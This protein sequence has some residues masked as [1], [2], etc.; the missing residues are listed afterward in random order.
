[1][2]DGRRM[3]R[4]IHLR[5]SFQP[6]LGFPPEFRIYRY[7]YGEFGRSNRP[8]PLCI[9][10][11][12]TFLPTMLGRVEG[13]YVGRDEIRMEALSRLPKEVWP[14][15]EPEIDSLIDVLLDL[16]EF[17]APGRR[18][19]A[20]HQR[21]LRV[22][23]DGE[24]RNITQPRANALDTVLLASLDP[25]IARILGLYWVDTE[26]DDP[27]DN[28]RFS[29]LGFRDY[30]V[31]GRW[32]EEPWPRTELDFDNVWWR[33]LTT[34]RLM[35]DDVQVSSN[36][37]LRFKQAARWIQAGRTGRVVS[38]NWHEVRFPADLFDQKPIFLTAMQTAHG[39][40]PVGVRIRGLDAASA[41]LRVE[42]DRRGP[43]TDEEVGHLALVSG[44]IYDVE[45]RPVGE[46]RSVRAE[47]DAPSEW[48]TASF[49]RVLSD[50]VVLMQIVTHHGHE[51]A[52]VRLKGVHGSGFK[53]K[54]EEW[55][56]LD[57]RHVE[58]ELN[59][60]ALERGVHRLTDGK[61]LEVGHVSTDHH[62]AEVDV[63]SA[64][65][66]VQRIVLSQAQSSEGGD[67]IIT[68]QRWL[69]NR[70][71]VR[72]QEGSDGGSHTIETVGYVV[73]GALDAEGE[74]G[75]RKPSIGE[76][77]ASGSSALPIHFILPHPV[78][79][80]EVHLDANRDGWVAYA[81]DQSP[82]HLD[83]HNHINVHEI[84][85]TRIRIVHDGASEGR[86][87]NRVALYHGPERADFVS[88]L[89]IHSFS[90]RTRSG[91][92]GDLWAETRW[93]FR[94][95]VDGEWV[96]LDYLS[97]NKARI[98]YGL[99][100]EEKYER[101][102][103]ELSV[104]PPAIRSLKQHALSPILG[105]GGEV[106]PSS[107]AVTVESYL[108]TAAYEAVRMNVRRGQPGLRE[109]RPRSPPIPSE[110]G[111]RDLHVVQAPGMFVRVAPPVVVTPAP[112]LVGQRNVDSLWEDP[113]SGALE[114]LI[115][116]NSN[117][118]RAAPYDYMDRWLTDGAYS[119]A[120]QG[121]DI[122][123]RVSEWGEEATINVIDRTPPPSPGGA[124][125]AYQSRLEGIVRTETTVRAG[126]DGI[127][128][129]RF[130]VLLDGG[131]R[132]PTGDGRLPL[133]G[134]DVD[135]LREARDATVR[136]TFRITSAAWTDSGDIR[137]EVEP[138]S[139]LT[140]A[141]HPEPGD[142]LILGY[143]L[144]VSVTWSW[145]GRQQLFHPGTREF[146]I[147]T[148]PGP[149]NAIRTHVVRVETT[150]EG[151]YT[152]DT[153]VPV[154]AVLTGRTGREVTHEWH[155]LTFP[156]DRL[157]GRPIFLAAMQ[158]AHGSDPSSVRVGDLNRE[159]AQFRVEEDRRGEHPRDERIAYLALAPGIVRDVAGRP[160][161]EARSLKRDQ[162][163]A[164]DPPR[165]VWHSV[166]FDREYAHPVV[167]MQ[168]ASRHGPQPA[169][170]RI[171]DVD[172]EGFR[173]KIEEWPHLDQEHVE[174]ELHFLAIEEGL[175]RLADGMLLEVGRVER[176]HRWDS[177][178]PV[179]FGAG[180]QGDP[181]VVYSQS[182]TVEGG[183]A[184]VTRQK[185]VS[186]RGFNVRLQEGSGDDGEH[187]LETVGYI[188]VGVDDAVHPLQ[189]SS[190]Q[191]DGHTYHLE[192]AEARASGSGR[193]LLRFHV[194][195]HA[196]PVLPPEEDDEVRIALSTTTGLMKEYTDAAI[197]QE[198]VGIVPLDGPGRYAG[199]V[200]EA[201]K[202]VA[203]ERAEL[204][205]R[206]DGIGVKLVTAEGTEVYR[207][208]LI[209]D[210]ELPDVGPE[211]F[212]P[213]ALTVGFDR[214]L[215]EP[216]WE[217]FD[218]L[219]HEPVRDDRTAVFI[220]VAP[221]ADRDTVQ[222]SD[223]N[224]VTVAYYYPGLRYSASV[225]APVLIPDGQATVETA[226]GVTATDGQRQTHDPRGDPDRYGNESRVFVTQAVAVDRARPPRPES[227]NVEID[228]ADYYGTSEATVEWMLP[229]HEE[230]SK[231]TRFNVYRATDTAVFAR[232]LQQR[233]LGTGPYRRERVDGAEVRDLFTAGSGEGFRPDPYFAEWF[234]TRFG[235]DERFADLF[236]D[237]AWFW[238]DAW[239]RILFLD[240]P[241]DVSEGDGD[242]A[243]ATW[244]EAWDKWGA[245]TDVWEAWAERFYPALTDQ[246]RKDL[247]ELEGNESAFVLVNDSP[248]PGRSIGY[249]VTQRTLDRLRSEE[250]PG[251]DGAALLSSLRSR[252][253]GKHFRG[254]RPFLDAL[255]DGLSAGAFDEYA[256]LVLR[257]AER[258]HID[259]VDGRVRNRYL[260]RIQSVGE[261]VAE[262]VGWSPASSP[263]APRPSRLPRA[264]SILEQSVVDGESVRLRWSFGGSDVVEYLVFRT[265]DDAGELD[266]L[267]YAEEFIIARL[268]DPRLRVAPHDD[269]PG[270]RPRLRVPPDHDFESLRAVYPSS[271]IIW[272]GSLPVPRQDAF[273]LLEP[274]EGRMSDDGGF[275]EGLRPTATGTSVVLVYEFDQG[276]RRVIPNL[277]G[278]MV[279][280]DSSPPRG[281]DISYRIAA[282]TNDGRRSTGSP[283]V[284]ARVPERSPEAPDLQVQRTPIDGASHSVQVSWTA[285]AGAEVLVQG[286]SPDDELWSSIGSWR[287]TATG[288]FDDVVPAGESRIFRAWARFVNPLTRN[289]LTSPPSPAVWAEASDEGGPGEP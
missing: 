198:R 88:H 94:T 126:E 79:A 264:P 237:A 92:I 106:P 165:P 133:A 48:K 91:P 61:V 271:E 130:D 229:R 277:T 230:L 257:H 83:A 245:A 10:K 31:E 222:S 214:G 256:S 102:L 212:V 20:Q 35:V 105:P 98:R 64:L 30:A 275:L 46:A 84:D 13:R 238:S 51:P 49:A 208:E 40:D 39:D 273:N 225:P 121:I 138:L 11:T 194:S 280:T 136:R 14:R 148:H 207:V 243:R 185:D 45:G 157:S 41:E 29:P 272:N 192:R 262:S 258:V 197:W 248:V 87:F 186:T 187:R 206:L 129:L 278:G 150:G 169:H 60:V 97:P 42:E 67:P 112:L 90:Y 224:P 161:G 149:L 167:F 95:A 54:I 9:K 236:S 228:W 158:T 223:F 27:V 115:E 56:H 171:R 166:E 5:W 28:W 254:R 269:W 184:I 132:I 217:V 131:E 69:E 137:L 135:T 74:A 124:T 6:E 43:H 203:E 109:F 281:I 57:G 37:A 276:P 221:S 285:D 242:E 23:I 122:F 142:R 53:Y 160:I 209:P 134:Y 239:I 182:Q 108:H 125:A 226:V 172:R 211:G 85:P 62:W 181:P 261:N 96:L 199:A 76:L 141:E 174:E 232:D 259:E 44:T 282:I 117:S 38:H 50:P 284:A 71:E 244:R 215:D 111:V 246:D 240:K 63:D 163:L 139:F 213:G 195:Y 100:S 155:E 216:E 252:M 89:H 288:E 78:E 86:R 220:R 8:T 193:H 200:A 205:T 233:R 250:L 128:L 4:G 176:D 202:L 152:V 75:V 201:A 231:G 267:R 156:S 268:P 36:R 143:D 260:Y 196:R 218:V 147:Y 210:E 55:P 175:H 164:G 99:S 151:Q 179:E 26:V 59:Y 251:E 177:G 255:E 21:P 146:R 65:D 189:A 289:R 168:L 116:S 72:L 66:G 190:C 145:T 114:P 7:S 119:Y 19:K 118:S 68:R 144:D 101:A 52:H 227:P 170:A 110:L 253:L 1:M 188:A 22:R 287:P 127:S 3:Q 16:T 73:V 15:Y 204:E 266:D 153:A 162:P 34:G 70:F 25:N 24:M 123:G 263:V 219:W 247:A 173:F 283:L 82:G 93:P 270:E 191:I 58:E 180:F 12:R 286:R 104:Q 47:Q 77:T 18:R 80:L 32:G 140:E 17:P 234:Q 159:G 279:W 103:A 274:G 178:D 2:F 183:Q 241:P 81:S 235:D 120:L 265:V 107:A 249:K 33:Q 154:S 113:E